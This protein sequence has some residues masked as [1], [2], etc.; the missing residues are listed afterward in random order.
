MAYNR[1]TKECVK[2]F[3]ETDMVIRSRK[4]DDR[5]WLVVDK[6]DKLVKIY[7]D[8]YAREM[9]DVSLIRTQDLERC[10]IKRKQLRGYTKA[11]LIDEV[12]AIAKANYVKKMEEW[13]VEED[14][15]KS[16]RLNKQKLVKYL[17]ANFCKLQ[18]K[19][20][21]RSVYCEGSANVKDGKLYVMLVTTAYKR[22]H[23]HDSIA[24]NDAFNYD[25][26]DILVKNNT[27]LNQFRSSLRMV[28]N[29]SYIKIVS[30]KTTIL[31]E[32][33][34]WGVGYSTKL[35]LNIKTMEQAQELI[36]LVSTLSYDVN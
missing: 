22:D 18:A 12:Y 32:D 6:A 4:G 27:A 30:N 16:K 35:R 3:V 19:S 5:A 21:N 17:N 11:K 31:S 7:S 20:Y 29:K 26:A 23:D 2:E 24:Y 28:K 25:D 15:H 9:T 10:Y 34:G 33:K 14:L 8:K 36:K 1:V 13:K